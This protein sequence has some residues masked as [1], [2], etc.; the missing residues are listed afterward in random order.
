MVSLWFVGQFERE[1][2]SRPESR[3]EFIGIGRIIEEQD[4]TD[5]RLKISELKPFQGCEVALHLKDGEVLR[6]KVVLVDS[7]YE[8][9]IVD[10]LETN[11]PEHYKDPNASYTVAA[12]GIISVRISN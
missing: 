7:G 11:Q 9:I 10:V 12:S 4:R 3:L 8:D 6:T 2:Q 1:T 5:V